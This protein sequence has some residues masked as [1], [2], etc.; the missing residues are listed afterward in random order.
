MV[1]WPRGPWYHGPRGQ[2]TQKRAY[3][4][5]YK[6]WYKIRFCTTFCTT[7]FAEDSSFFLKIIPG[8]LA[9]PAPPENHETLRRMQILFVFSLSRG[10]GAR[11]RKRTSHSS[12]VKGHSAYFG[13]RTSDSKVSAVAFDFP[14]EQGLFLAPRPRAPGQ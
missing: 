1:H 6:M 14:C 13:I 4:M 2:C 3:K 8:F 5:G 7:F 11:R 10:A 9:P 12:K